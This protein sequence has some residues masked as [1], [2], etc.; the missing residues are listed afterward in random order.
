MNNWRKEKIYRKKQ[1]K[2]IEWGYCVQNVLFLVSKS[3]NARNVCEWRIWR[4][5][6]I[7]MHHTCKGDVMSLLKSMS[8]LEKRTKM[9]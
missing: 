6:D 3:R 5:I 2:H 7:H 1:Q 9:V 4:Y 8:S